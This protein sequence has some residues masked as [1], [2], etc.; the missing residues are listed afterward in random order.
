MWYFQYSLWVLTVYF[1]TMEK[2][3]YGMD[4]NTE[5]ALHTYYVQQLKGSAYWLEKELFQDYLRSI[6]AQLSRVGVRI[7]VGHGHGP[8]ITCI[9]GTDRKRQKKSMVCVF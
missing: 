1:M 9:S 3:F 5:G 6:F 7:V 2:S 4:I 8:S